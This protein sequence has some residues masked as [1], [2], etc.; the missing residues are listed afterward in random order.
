MA[1]VPWCITGAS[2]SHPLLEGVSKDLNIINHEHNL[3]GAWG[4]VNMGN[5]VLKCLEVFLKD[6]V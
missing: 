1:G 5:I 6:T 2:S 3:V 4:H